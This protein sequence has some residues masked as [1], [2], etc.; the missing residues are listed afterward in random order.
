MGLSPLFSDQFGQIS[1]QFE[2]IFPVSD[3]GKIIR[4]LKPRFRYFW[5]QMHLTPKFDLKI[6][7]G[8]GSEPK[9]RNS[10]KLC[11]IPKI[12]YLKFE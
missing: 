12:L 8:T 11:H 4:S 9:F 6:Q 5:E 2:L 7:T 3:D 10:Q 1:G